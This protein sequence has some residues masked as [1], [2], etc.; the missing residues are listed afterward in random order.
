MTLHFLWSEVKNKKIDCNMTK[1]SCSETICIYLHSILTEQENPCF[2]SSPK[3]KKTEIK[4]QRT[5]DPNSLKQFE[6]CTSMLNVQPVLTLTRIW[7]V[8]DRSNG[9]QDGDLHILE[10]LIMEQI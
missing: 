8:G 5:P 7:W 3:W 4:K 9:Q 1:D 6:K 10:T 2:Q